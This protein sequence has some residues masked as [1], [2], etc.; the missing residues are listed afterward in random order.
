M[1]NEVKGLCTVGNEDHSCTMQLETSEIILRG[2]LRARLP[3][4]ELKSLRAVDDILTFTH[5]RSTY[6]LH[7]GNQAAKWLQKITHPKSVIEKL[8]VK[9]GMKVSLVGL[10]EEE[11]SDAPE[12]EL[13]AASAKN[14]DWI[15]LR[16][17]KA[18]D[19][20]KIAQQAKRL[21]PKGQLWTIRLRGNEETGEAIVRQ[22]GLDAGLVDVKVVRFSETE[23]AEKFVRRA[24]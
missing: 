20:A 11:L 23:T 18:G 14:C 15:A 21:A 1:G 13:V 8:G 19:L 24:T 12:I 17:K 3:F 7:L 9:A 16:L 5:A 10:N 22:A 2:A 4:G 6:R